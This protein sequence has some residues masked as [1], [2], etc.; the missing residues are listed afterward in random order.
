MSIVPHGFHRAI[1]IIVLARATTRD[2]KQEGWEFLRA[3]LQVEG[4]RRTWSA[5]N[6]AQPCEKT[7]TWAQGALIASKFHSLEQ[8][9]VLDCH[10]FAVCNGRLNG[11]STLIHRTHIEE[12]TQADTCV[13]SYMQ[14]RDCLPMATENAS[15]CTGKEITS[16]P[17]TRP[18]QKAPGHPT[19]QSLSGP[20][21]Y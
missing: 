14:S 4:N 2:L 5:K 16:T 18:T 3:A 21:Q 15:L 20:P 11:V 9:F 12:T 6:D 8:S 10:Y 19:H 13:V 17:F 7:L 1:K